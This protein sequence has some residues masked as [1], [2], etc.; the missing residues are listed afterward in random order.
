MKS[1]F[2]SRNGFQCPIFFTF[3]LSLFRHVQ[4]K[5]CSC[6]FISSYF[7]WISTISFCLALWVAYYI[8]IHVPFRFE[9]YIRIF[10]PM[11]I[12]P[13]YLSHFL[14]EF[15]IVSIE[16]S[17]QRS[18]LGKYIV[19]YWVPKFINHTHI[20]IAII[21]SAFHSSPP[22]FS[23]TYTQQKKDINYYSCVAINLFT[24]ATM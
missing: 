13:K 9:K 3:S 15:H 19:I 2:K 14:D 17:A 24:K 8:F 7:D 22:P 5:K 21:I 11:A 16:H 18:S 20:F 12:S 23:H 10:I 4:T 1:I 6:I